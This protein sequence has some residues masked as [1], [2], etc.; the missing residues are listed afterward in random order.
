MKSKI[1]IKQNIKFFLL[2][3][4][5]VIII[6]SIYD[7]KSTIDSFKKGFQYSNH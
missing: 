6:E 1:R 4:I 5:S 2:G 3:M 7:W